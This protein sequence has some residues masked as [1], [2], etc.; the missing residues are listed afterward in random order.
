[1]DFGPIIE[2]IA[3][4]GGTELLVALGFL[5]YMHKQGI[6]RDAD[7]TKLSDELRTVNRERIADLEKHLV[8]LA[9]SRQL[10]KHLITKSGD[11]FLQLKSYFDKSELTSAEILKEVR[12][13]QSK[14]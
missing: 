7:N 14:I 5:W 9:E 2:K 10:M 3:E 11:N 12:D 8:D 13:I 1:M 6:K 4:T